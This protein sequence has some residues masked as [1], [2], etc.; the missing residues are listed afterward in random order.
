MI[1][2]LLQCPCDPIVT[3]AFETF[4]SVVKELNEAGTSC[5]DVTIANVIC[6]SLIIIV[7][8]GVAGFLA[9][10]IIDHNANEKERKFKKEKE[11]E[12]S[13][14]KQ[15]LFL[16]EM[17]LSE[18]KNNNTAEYLAALDQAIKTLVL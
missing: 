14:R 3:K 12:E 7:A 5:Y 4:I 2:T 9:W 13:E 18:L 15:K 8:I 17:K 11:K 10:K 16:L 1:T 6:K